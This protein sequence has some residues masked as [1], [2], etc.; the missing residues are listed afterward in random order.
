MIL[1]R[2]TKNVAHVIV[3]DQSSF[4]KNLRRFILFL[5]SFYSATPKQQPKMSLARS[6]R[7]SNLLLKQVPARA[8][9]IAFQKYR[10]YSKE[11]GGEVMHVTNKT[12]KDSVLDSSIPTIVDFYADW[13][14][15]CRMLSPI[16]EAAVK[17][18]GKVNLAKIDTE[19]ESDLAM[20]YGI[21]SLPTIIVFKDGET[22]DSFIG[23]KD[24]KF[25]AEFI[26]KIE[27][28]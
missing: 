18:S 16:L 10:M 23:F 17:G 24:K 12:F 20:Q 14:G 1:V 22:T 11:R 6:F 15:P 19:Q 7:F 9:A 4:I 21:T 5:R 2:D 3:C 8:N 13:C 25:L 27:T 26:Q 28:N